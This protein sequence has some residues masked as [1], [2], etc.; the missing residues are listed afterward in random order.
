MP[1]DIRTPYR[2]TVQPRDVSEAPH[3]HR[4]RPASAPVLPALAQFEAAMALASEVVASLRAFVT[5]YDGMDDMLG[6]TVLARVR[7]GRA[8]LAK[9]D[10]R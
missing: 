9:V 5:A 2:V 4:E 6:D 10:Q 8:V 7:R 3:D 1:T